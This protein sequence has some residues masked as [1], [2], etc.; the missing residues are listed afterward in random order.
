MKERLRSSE[1]VRGAR[2]SE[3]GG[4]LEACG[5]VKEHDEASKTGGCQSSL[6]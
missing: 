1:W 3:V 5:K 4:V 6:L 2:T